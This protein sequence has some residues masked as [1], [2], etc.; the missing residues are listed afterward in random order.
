MPQLIDISTLAACFK[1]Y[2]PHPLH[3]VFRLLQPVTPSAY[4]LLGNTVN[5]MFDAVVTSTPADFSPLP[6]PVFEASPSP[7]SPLPLK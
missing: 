1:E 5:T 3:Y 7:S 4:N 2:G 6:T